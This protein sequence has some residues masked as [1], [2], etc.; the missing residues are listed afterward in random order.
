MGAM[1]G[2]GMG[3]GI[4]GGILGGIGDIMSATKYKPPKLPPATGQEQRLRQLASS[5]LMGGGQQLLGAT[6]LYNQLAPILLS[7]LPGMHYNPGTGGGGGMTSG[8]GDY[9]SA[10]SNQQ[11]QQDLQQQF[12]DVKRQ[13]KA[14]KGKGAKQ[15]LRQQRNQL[16]QQLKGMPTADQETRRMYLAGMQPGSFDIQQGPPATGQTSLGDIN[17]LMSSLGSGPNLMDLYRGAGG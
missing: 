11:H 10:L 5:Q 8:A 4:M 1:G 17:S 12:N 9:G 7:Q 16:R 6:A 14:A 15:P 13:L 2:T 3:L